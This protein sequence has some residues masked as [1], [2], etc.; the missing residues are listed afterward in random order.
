[1]KKKNGRNRKQNNNRQF[2]DK[3]GRYKTGH[4]IIR[5]MRNNKGKLE[6]DIKKMENE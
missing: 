4:E 3:L 5:G 1:M 2:Y 6:N